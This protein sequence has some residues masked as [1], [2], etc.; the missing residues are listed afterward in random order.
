[1]KISSSSV[2]CQPVLPGRR[3]TLTAAGA[4]LLA[5]AAHGGRPLAIDDAGTVP[6]GDFE[7]EAGVMLHREGGLHDYEFP[8]GLTAGLFSTLETGIGFGSQIQE[9]QETVGTSTTTGVGDLALGAKWNPLPEEKFWVSHALA[10]TV[11]FP[12]ASD[13]KG[14]G[15]GK[16]DYDLTYI[17]SK[18]LSDTWSAHLNAGYTWTGDPE[19]TPEDDLFHAGLA[20]GWRAAEKLELVAEVFANSPEGLNDNATLEWSGGLRWNL[21]DN[22]ILDAAGGSRVRGEAPDLTATLGLTWTLSKSKQL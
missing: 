6:P 19:G 7:L 22:L 14:L 12:T 13:N 16:T 11:K 9:R 18:S 15:T 8:F 10:F 21:R 17:A 4:I 3:V 2:K 20:L 5:V 1:M